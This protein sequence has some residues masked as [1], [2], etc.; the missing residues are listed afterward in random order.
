MRDVYRVGRAVALALFFGGAA[1][2]AQTGG[3]GSDAQSAGVDGSGGIAQPAGAG[4]SVQSSG[5]APRVAAG[6]GTTS[7]PTSR[8]STFNRVTTS[9]KVAVPAPSSQA[10]RAAASGGGG[11]AAGARGK[12]PKAAEVPADSSARRMPERTTRS[13]ATAMRAVTH[14]YYPGLRGGQYVNSN[15]ARVANGAR[16]RVPVGSGLGAGGAGARSGSVSA[17]RVGAPATAA[18]PRR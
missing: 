16:G 15:T 1:A 14:N 3:T 8:M 18:P 17:G 7:P 2:S 13:P 4:A 11:S 5:S 10:R 6:T 9:R 12:T